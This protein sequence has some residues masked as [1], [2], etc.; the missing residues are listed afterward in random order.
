MTPKSPLFPGRQGSVLIPAV[1]LLAVLMVIFPMLV[2]LTREDVRSSVR[3]VHR[4]EGL[5][6]AEAGL[7][8]GAWKLGE[9]DALWFQASTTTIPIPDYDFDRVWTDLDPDYRYKIRFSS[10]PRGGEVTIRCRVQSV[11]NPGFTRELAGVYTRDFSEALLM[12][13]DLD[14]TSTYFPR[15]HWGAIKSYTTLN[16]DGFGAPIFPSMRLYPRKYARRGIGDR[17]TVANAVNTDGNE[18]WAFDKKVV[19]PPVIDLEYY[20]KRA[21]NSSVPDTQAGTDGYLRQLD[22]A[23]LPV[24]DPPGSGFF[25]CGSN[26]NGGQGLRFFSFNPPGR[27]YELRNST[28]V[29]VIENDTAGACNNFVGNSHNNHKVFLEL[30][31]LVLASPGGGMNNLKIETN[32]SLATGLYYNIGSS[33]PVNARE[34]YAVVPATWNATLIPPNGSTMEAIHTAGALF[35]VPKVGF[36]GF[37]YVEKGTTEIEN[38]DNF[39]VLGVMY[40]DRLKTDMSGGGRFILYLDPLVQSRLKVLYAPMR[41]RSYREVLGNLW[42]SP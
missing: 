11:K 40:V 8:R 10:G 30:E 22:N 38:D 12:R 31:A 6:V 20:R 42:N 23:T 33:I 13:R 26:N 17:D 16:L 4:E 21:M 28:N 7:D 5:A 35:T 3:R 29:I 14:D 27:R 25:R 34:E 32:Q 36:R 41:R 18:Y 39:T 24:A 37:L 15:V 2:R 9:S 19:D 1:L